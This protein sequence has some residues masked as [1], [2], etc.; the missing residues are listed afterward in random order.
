MPIYLSIV[1]VCDGCYLRFASVASWGAWLG[2]HTT[3]LLDDAPITSWEIWGS[4]C[5]YLGWRLSLVD[6]CF[7]QELWMRV[8][9]LI[10]LWDVCGVDHPV[11]SVG[12][13][14]DGSN[15]LVFY[16]MVMTIDRLTGWLARRRRCARDKACAQHPRHHHHDTQ[17]HLPNHHSHTQR[18]SPN[19]SPT[20]PTQ[21]TPTS[22]PQHHTEPYPPSPSA[23]KQIKR[24][25]AARPPAPRRRIAATLHARFD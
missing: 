5:Q 15:S 13:S 4:G 17:R 1:L 19:P 24:I 25:S 6:W 16:G 2:H 14:I 22:L 11:L 18:P 20:R 8:I 7:S 21:P 3:P 10:V 12:A 9:A 23:P